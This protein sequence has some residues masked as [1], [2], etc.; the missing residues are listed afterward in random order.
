MKKILGIAAL[1]LLLTGTGKALAA[2]QFAR[3]FG[4]VPDGVTLNTASIQAAIDFTSAHGGGKVILDKGDYVTG[5][6]YLKDGVT[7]WIDPECS[8]L[9]SLNPFDYI[10]DPDAK[11]TAL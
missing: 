2:D 1:A 7:L 5:S 11:W 3:D 10:K 9:G 8:L 6:I 4:A